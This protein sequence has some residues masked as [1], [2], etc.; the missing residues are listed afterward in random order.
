MEAVVQEHPMGCGIACVAFV[1]KKSY[2]LILKLTNES[3][4][5]IKGYYCR[6]LVSFLKRFG[7][8][9][10]YKKFKEDLR[11]YLDIE[12][13]IVFIKRSQKFPE[14]HYLARSKNGWMNPWIN[15]PKINPA[16][17]GITKKLPEKVQWILF[18]TFI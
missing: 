14:G 13:T 12:G 4:A 7:L 16:K 10:E 18:K 5:S 1:T 8:K 17:A 15:Y 9:Y 2:S 11:K 3:K 6:E